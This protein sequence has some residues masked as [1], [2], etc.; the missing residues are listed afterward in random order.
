[1]AS[2]GNRI[3]PVLFYVGV[4]NHLIFI[5]IKYY[6]CAITDFT[7]TGDTAGGYM[8][9][10]AF[11]FFFPQLAIGIAVLIYFI[12]KILINIGDSHLTKRDIRYSTIYFISFG[13]VIIANYI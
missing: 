8:M 12:I 5:A 3:H 7:C 11:T 10:Y 1:M 2:H 9:M 13:I 4:I 6:V